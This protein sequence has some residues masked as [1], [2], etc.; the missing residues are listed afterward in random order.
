MVRLSFFVR[1]IGFHLHVLRYI[2]YDKLKFINYL[3]DVAMKYES[4]KVMKIGGER[5]NSS[6]SKSYNA[7]LLVGIYFFNLILS[8]RLSYR[9]KISVGRLKM[10]MSSSRSVNKH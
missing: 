9:K 1:L 6:Y 3:L 7:H 8:S 2:L 4:N 5:A 10:K